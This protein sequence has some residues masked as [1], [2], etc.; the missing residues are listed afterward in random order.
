MLCCALL[1]G[2]D[3]LGSHVMQTKLLEADA[4]PR[5]VAIHWLPCIC[6]LQAALSTSSKMGDLRTAETD[7]HW[8][9]LH[10]ISESV[11]P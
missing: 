11:L 5:H 2:K 10:T 7:I 6:I 8:A 1:W 3:V 4:E 9:W